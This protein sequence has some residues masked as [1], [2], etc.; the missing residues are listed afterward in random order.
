MSLCPVVEC[1]GAF[2]L[3]RGDVFCPERFLRIRP[4]AS[5]AATIW[6]DPC[7][8]V[9]DPSWTEDIPVL[10]RLSADLHHGQGPQAVSGLIER[11]RSSWT[12]IS[13]LLL[14]WSIAVPHHTFMGH[15][16]IPTVKYTGHGLLL[17]LAVTDHRFQW[18]HG[19]TVG[20]LL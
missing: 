5:R 6:V 20:Q 8:E 7:S 14:A 19:I 1:G 16:I 3:R 10:L 18:A 4:S 13:F 2:L 12:F 17:L 11:R 9:F 15:T